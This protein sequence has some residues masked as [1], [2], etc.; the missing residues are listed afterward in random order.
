MPLVGETAGTVFPGAIDTQ[1]MAEYEPGVI[2]AVKQL[3]F[4]EGCIPVGTLAGVTSQSVPDSIAN[5][6]VTLTAGTVTQTYIGLRAG[7][8]VT[9]LSIITGATPATTPTNQWA[10]LA[11]PVGATPLVVAISPDGLTAA[12]AANT[13][14]SFTLTTPYVV[15]TTG[16]YLAFVCV[17]A[18]TGPTAAAG[19]SLGA[20]GRGAIAPFIAGPG[21]TAKTTPPA[22]GVALTATSASGPQL[23][24]YAN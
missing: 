20:T 11:S 15:P 24:V 7:Q 9:K 18:T 2:E 8:T 23:L 4:S 10:G 17:A 22:I 21:G 1:Y 13:V 19:T 3:E 16:W 14:I 5:T 12:M 6:S